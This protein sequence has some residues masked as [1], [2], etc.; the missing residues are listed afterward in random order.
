MSRSMALH[1][2]VA[3]I[4]LCALLADCG[5]GQAITQ[6][7]FEREAS[8]GASIMSAAAETLRFVHATPAGMTVEYGAGSMINYLDQVVSLPDD[9]RGADGAPDEAT[10]DRLNVVVQP[11]IA[12]IENPC[13]L[14]GCD[15]STQVAV[16]DAARDALLIA[17]N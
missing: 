2:S 11:A 17:V 8:D 13:L 15:Y 12:V 1:R 10:L 5:S 3:L 6:T 9:L 16:L 7:G 4:A 14:S